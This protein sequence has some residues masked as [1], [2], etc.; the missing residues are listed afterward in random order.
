VTSEQPRL[1]T[2]LVIGAPKTG[3][4]SLHHYLAAH[5]QIFM[6]E[7]KEL[8]F[9]ITEFNWHR[10]IGWYRQQFMYAGP[11]K[12]V[13]EASPRYTQ[14]PYHRGVAERVFT[15]V[16]DAQLVYVIRDPV[17]QMLSHY[18]D[19]RRYATE[20]AP[21]NEALLADPVYLETAKY[22]CQLDQFLVHFPRDQIQIV[23][24]EQLRASE[25]RAATLARLLDFLGVD[26]SWTTDTLF[27][28]HNI[29]PPPRRWL[30]QRLAATRAWDAAANARPDWMKG[31][32][33]PII[34]RSTGPDLELSDAVA[35]EL[36][37][38]LR[39][40]AARLREIVG[41]GFD[42]WGIA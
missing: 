32:L 34:H 13:G 24:S 20:R 12:A 36:M 18:R 5:P 7:A 23:V 4:T 41:P 25:T 2:F 17:A 9:F 14:Y 40:D 35:R 31:P 37:S 38:R 27:E 19:R 29:G 26:K 10:G 39:D 11:A 15:V 8:D 28:E 42:G 21:V 16:P 33:R 6:A 22:G 30:F 1:P 3:T